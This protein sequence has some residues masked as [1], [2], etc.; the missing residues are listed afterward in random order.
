MDAS[1]PP[2]GTF[3]KGIVRRAS[4]RARAPATDGARSRCDQVASAPMPDPARAHDAVRLALFDLVSEAELTLRW[5][6]QLDASQH[7][8]GLTGKPPP[9]SPLADTLSHRAREVAGRVQA[10]EQRFAA[11]L[12]ASRGR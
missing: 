5:L 2:K 8:E 1:L 6:E 4:F 11:A 10:F 9:D 3:G 12:D 7:T